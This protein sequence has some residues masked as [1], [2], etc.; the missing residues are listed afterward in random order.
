L[1]AKRTSGLPIGSRFERQRELSNDFGGDSRLHR[2]ASVKSGL[3]ESMRAAASSELILMGPRPTS[4]S[5]RTM[6]TT[7]GRP[8]AD[9]Q[10]PLCQLTSGELSCCKIDLAWHHVRREIRGS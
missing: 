8:P 1:R 3:L 5:T 9:P 2:S 7:M 6:S 10:N 4:Y